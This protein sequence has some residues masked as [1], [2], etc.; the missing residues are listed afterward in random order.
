MQAEIIRIHKGDFMNKNS[1]IVFDTFKF[2]L[3]AKAKESTRYGLDRILI[4]NSNIVATNGRILFFA[5][6]KH[7][8]PIGLYEVITNTATE[9]ILLKEPDNGVMTFP[10][11]REVVP[12]HTDYFEKDSYDGKFVVH[13]TTVLA[14]KKIA[15]DYCYVEKIAAI[16]T[17]WKIFYGNSEQPIRFVSDNNKDYHYEAIVMPFNAGFDEI[18]F[19]KTEKPIKVEDL[20]KQ[21]SPEELVESKV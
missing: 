12:E 11:W 5:Y 9:I 2:I 10:K 18:I 8:Y 3:T 21:I 1:R 6:F 14:S 20:E 16:E 19:N 15:I 4:E 17:Y 13:A 7:K